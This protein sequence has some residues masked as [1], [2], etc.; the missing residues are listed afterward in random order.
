MSGH[1]KYGELVLDLPD[2]QKNIAR[3]MWSIFT[4]ATNFRISDLPVTPF[5]IS[6][7]GLFPISESFQ[8][9]LEGKIEHVTMKYKLPHG[10]DDFRTSEPLACAFYLVNNLHETLLPYHKLDKYG[11]YPYLESIQC[12]N[13]LMEVNYVQDIFDDIYE[14]LTGDPVVQ[15][16]SKLMWTHD[17]D[18]LYSAWKSD[19][20]LAM[21]DSRYLDIPGLMWSALTTPH[22]RN[23]IPEILELE[24]EYDIRSIFFWLTER[25]KSHVTRSHSIDH[26]DYSFQMKQVQKYWSQILENGSKHGLHKSA[27]QGNMDG[28]LQKMPKMVDINRNHFLRFK[29]PDHYDQVEKAGLQYDASLGFPE[30]YGFRN[31]FGRPFRPY[32]LLKNRAYRFTEYPLHLMDATFLTYLNHDLETMTQKMTDFIHRHHNSCTI[33]IL[34]HNSYFEFNDQSQMAIW[35]RFFKSVRGIE[36]VLPGE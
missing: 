9:M 22:R 28:E 4:G 19:L 33:S 27:Y 6:S 20:I 24:K 7:S 11:R 35:N 30:H 8:D 3:Y 36:W 29:L 2:S 25:G 1:S 12:A 21:R 23:N 16:A 31:S 34:L 5:V 17:I 13:N 10:L 32:D 15:E 26:A 18:Y 14:G